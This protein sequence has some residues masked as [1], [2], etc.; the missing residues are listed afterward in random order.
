VIATPATSS[1][2]A[3]MYAELADQI[4]LD[5]DDPDLLCDP[6]DMTDGAQQL[7]YWGPPCYVAGLEMWL[8]AVEAAGNLDSTAVRDE[9][10]KFS[11]TNPCDTVLGDTWFRVFGFDPVT[12]APN[13]AGGGILDYECHP[14]Q[15]GQWQ[16]GVYEIVGGNEPTATFDYPNTGNWFWLLD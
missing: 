16:S 9:L 5:W 1:E 12:G 11:S 6:G 14:G 7:E 4:E 3:Q 15:I 10:V 13:Q 2:M 8:A